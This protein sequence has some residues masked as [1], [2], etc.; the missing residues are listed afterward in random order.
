MDKTR[1]RKTRQRNAGILL[2]IGDFALDISKRTKLFCN[3]LELL[4]KKY[5]V[6]H[7]KRVKLGRHSGETMYRRQLW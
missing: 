5:S 3:E 6:K 7:A 2:V 1:R 4:V